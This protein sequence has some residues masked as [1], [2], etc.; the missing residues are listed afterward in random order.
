MPLS[1]QSKSHGSIAFGFFNI[2]SDMLLL[3]NHFFFATEFCLWIRELAGSREDADFTATWPVF[4]IERREEI[5]DLMG[6]IHGIRHVG[7]IGDTYLA[8]PFPE[9]PEEFKQRP[10]GDAT[11]EE[12]TDLIAEYAV[13][14]ELPVTACRNRDCIALGEYL[15][16][17]ESFQ[18]LIGYVWRGGFPQW[19][20]HQAPEYVVAMQDE[21]VR[22]RHWLLAGFE[23]VPEN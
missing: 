16:S 21:A 19:L 20:D 8:Y 5:G 9:D 23:K 12:F 18:E 1:F 3:E 4:H 14:V 11:Q 13:R 10:S 7:F 15:F 6:A 2:E 22:S 17:R